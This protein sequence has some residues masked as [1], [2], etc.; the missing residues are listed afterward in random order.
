MG[1][2]RLTIEVGDIQEER[3]EAVEVLV[4]TGSTYCQIPSSLLHRLGIPVRWEAEVRLADGRIVT[5]E[6]GQASIRLEGKTFATPVIFGREG[7][8][9]LL[10]V[11]AL[12]T[13]LLT[14]DPVEQRLI[15]TIG[16][17]A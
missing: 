3:F 5:D 1:E 12:G 16:W 9:N 14:V 15:S 10:G 2:V 11:V 8:P 17:K 4:D 7:E 13:A 6:V